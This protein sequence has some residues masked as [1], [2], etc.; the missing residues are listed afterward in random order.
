MAEVLLT[1]FAVFL[2]LAGCFV[3]VMLNAEIQ[4]LRLLSKQQQKD[5]EE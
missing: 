2:T 4:E 3:I 1:L 5:K